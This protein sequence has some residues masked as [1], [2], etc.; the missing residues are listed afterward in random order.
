VKL[1]VEISGNGPPIVLLHGW[2]LHSGVWH[3]LRDAMSASWRVHCVD[4]PGHGR[5]AWPASIEDLQGIARHILPHVPNGAAVL[6][7]SLGGMTALALARLAP[8]RIARLILVATTPRFVAADDWPHG[9]SPGLLAGFATRL[10][11]DYRRT[12]SEF[13]ALQVRGAENEAATLRELRGRLMNH[14][15][16]RPQALAVG[17]DILRRT[18]LRP[19]LARIAAP[20]LVFAGQYDRVTPPEAGRYVAE[21][22]PNARYRLI[23]RAGHAPFISHRSEFV[24]EL[25]RF[26]ARGRTHT[27]AE[28]PE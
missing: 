27:T 4:L 19:E 18:D 25:E 11:V 28:A 3:D 5:S 12:I 21:Q 2:G 22:L 7:W 17:L 23:E 15:T 10:Q 20:T 9:M 14:E 8:R 26:L 16:L 13:L 6:G 1:H 24:V